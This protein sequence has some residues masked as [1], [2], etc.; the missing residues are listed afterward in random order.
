V[1][2]FTPTDFLTRKLFQFSVVLAAQRVCAVET[3]GSLLE[4]CTS[5]SDVSPRIAAPSRQGRSA[6][7]SDAPGPLRCQHKLI[8]YSHTLLMLIVR[9]GMLRQCNAAEKARFI[10]S[11]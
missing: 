10:E 9:T 3:D 7:W 4:R 8:F 6:A 11:I 2:N 5:K 1:D